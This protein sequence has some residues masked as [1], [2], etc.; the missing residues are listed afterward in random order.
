[1][2]TTGGGQIQYH[3]FAD[4]ALPAI[5]HYLIARGSI[6]ITATTVLSGS[7]WWTVLHRECLFLQ[8]SCH[9]YAQQKE[10]SRYPQ[11]EVILGG[12]K[13]QQ[14]KHTVGQKNEDSCPAFPVLI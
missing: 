13:G 12:E 6:Y 2:T 11:L 8:Q 14:K 4:C 10:N 7:Q 3:V 1:M 5:N 9:H